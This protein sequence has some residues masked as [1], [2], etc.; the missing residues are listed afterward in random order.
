VTGGCD[1]YRR[2][3]AGL[4]AASPLLNPSEVSRWLG[5]NS[6]TTTV[7]LYGHLVPEATA[8]ARTALDGRSPQPGQPPQCPGPAHVH[9]MC[10][11]IRPAAH[12]HRSAAR[13]GVSRPV[14]RVLC[15]RLRGA[16]VI[17]LGLPLP[18]ASCGLPASIGRAALERS[19]RLAS[20]GA[21]LLTLLR[22]G[23]TEPPQSPA[24]LVV[25]YTTVSPLPRGAGM[26][27]RGAVCFLWH[28][29]AGHPGSALP[30][31]LPCGARTFLT[32][33]QAR[34]DRPADSPAFRIRRR[35]VPRVC[36]R[37]APR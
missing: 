18:T 17:H 37:C 15:A 31:T 28:C 1:A 19:R 34:R 4:A 22:V 35:R 8:R 36:W 3:G 9:P 33:P 23:F 5:H 2:H 24:A 32:G 20:S 27:R 16:T 13:E 11:R 14:G 21:A 10:T 29:P 30:T 25:S 26:P 12:R 6:I 7:D